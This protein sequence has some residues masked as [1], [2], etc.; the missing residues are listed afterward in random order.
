M[1]EPRHCN[2]RCECLGGPVGMCERSQLMHLTFMCDCNVLIVSFIVSDRS[3]THTNQIS[4]QKHDPAG[5][6]QAAPSAEKFK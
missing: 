2:I 3:K 6:S 5:E 1:G 4:Y